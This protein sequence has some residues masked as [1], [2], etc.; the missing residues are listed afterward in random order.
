MNAAITSDKVEQL[1]KLLALHESWENNQAKKAYI[2]AMSKAQAEMR[3]VGTDAV[4]PQTRSNYATYTKLDNVLRPIYTKHGFNLSFDT[5]DSQ[6]ENHIKILCYVSHENG[7]T[8]THSIDMPNDGKGAKGTAVMTLTHATGSATSYGMRYLLKMIF[9]VA[10]GED[11]NDGNGATEPSQSTH[12]ELYKKFAHLMKTTLDNVDSVMTIKQAIKENDL[13]VAI[14]A[15]LELDDTTKGIL[16]VATT[17]GGPFSTEERSIM[18]S[19]EWVETRN[20]IFQG[21]K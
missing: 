8:K 3:A 5:T 4:N 1:D 11:D 12:E 13:T 14:E 17:K 2:E 19:N 7:F 16:W 9:N 15:W 18:K 20:M 6:K 10:V 21:A